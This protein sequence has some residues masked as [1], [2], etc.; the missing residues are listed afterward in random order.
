METSADQVA[1]SVDLSSISTNTNQAL[2]DLKA[3]TDTAAR[4]V[5][6]SRDLTTSDSL[7]AIRTAGIYRVPS[8]SVASAVGAPD[9]SVGSVEVRDSGYVGAN[10]ISLQEAWSLNRNV[11]WR[12]T[13][14]SNG[15]WSDWQ[16]FRPSD[17]SS[18]RQRIAL[19]NFTARRGGKIGT[20]GRA[21]VALR[22]DH[23]TQ[24][25]QAKVLPL[26]RQYR[27]P[28][29][30]N[31]NAAA[32]GTGD[33]TMTF[34]QMQAAAIDQGGEI[35]NHSLNHSDSTVDSGIWP[36]IV[37]GLA[38][39]RAN[40]PLLPVEGWHLPGVGGS[41]YNGLNLGQT[42]DQ[43]A[44]Y[45]GSLVLNNHAVASGGTGGIYI[46]LDGTPRDGRNY[47]TLDAQSLAQV[48][49]VVNGAV[50][51]KAGV[52]LMLHSSNLDQDGYMSTATLSSVLSYIADQRKAGLLTV[53]TNGG[54]LCADARSDERHNLLPGLFTGSH[55]WTGWT[56]TSG[57]ATGSTTPMTRT[58]SLAR[59]G[60]FAGGTRELV[61][62]GKS[63]GA[64]TVTT[65]VTDSQGAHV[66]THSLPAG[67]GY[68]AMRQFFTVPLDSTSF[69]VSVAAS[70]STD[71]AR[72]DCLAA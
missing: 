42:E 6:F 68:L 9:A 63:A 8:Q 23:H 65:T 36:R 59:E 24:D 29:S 69:T 5:V 57:V 28:W 53:L 71:I 31:I 38:Q 1:L 7:N 62:Y 47:T 25:F 58:V 3:Y 20:G 56:V 61:V 27:L 30:L 43:W 54:L 15:N 2:N 11:F 4:D 22:F 41:G 14:Q 26:L 72:I 66:Q 19:A 55:G 60:H 10:K 18:A 39:L 49:G 67:G 34:D 50:S 48:Q 37:T 52:V 70:S 12:R 46:P 16:E 44:T 13:G 32:V 33:D 21:V 17:A 40:F 45:A 35:W 64:S 51:A